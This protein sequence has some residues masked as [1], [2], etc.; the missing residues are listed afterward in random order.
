M[1]TTPDVKEESSRKKDEEQTL[2]AKALPGT[3]PAVTPAVS[4]GIHTQQGAG[5]P[6]GQSE[7]SFYEGRMNRD[8][9]H[10]RV[11]DDAHAAATA[12]ELSAHAFTYGQ[13]IF[14]GAGRHQPH[15]SEGR[16]LLAHELVH[17]MQQRPSGVARRIQRQAGGQP[18]GAGAG[19]GATT[20]G[21][22]A[23]PAAPSPA[24]ATTFDEKEGRLD[25]SDAADPKVVFSSIELPGFKYEGDRKTHYDQHMPL[26]QAKNYERGNPQQREFWRT[27]LDTKTIK[28]RL[29]QIHN[30]KTSGGGEG[31]LFAAPKDAK[32]PSYFTGNLDTIATMLLTPTW[33]ESGAYTRFDVDHIV[34]L[35]LANWPDPS[36]ETWANKLE[37]MWLLDQKSNRSSGSVIAQTINQKADA[38]S[39]KAAGDQ[40][41]PRGAASVRERYPLVFRGA[42]AGKS[43]PPTFWER[44]NIEGGKQL[45]QVRVA[46]QS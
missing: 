20:G 1:T 27:N 10:V 3:V 35:Q 33:D 8:L 18:G 9:S 40:R 14:F 42:T 36:S 37:N 43:E 31:Y 17:T 30:E 23:T 26:R 13:D 24:D 19:G 29:T 25:L 7:R 6:L 34:E 15:T 39:K 38:F 2:A 21:A 44:K 12:R 28:D 32:D 22:G 4:A 5:R 11:H 46:H 16:R 45:D 41:I